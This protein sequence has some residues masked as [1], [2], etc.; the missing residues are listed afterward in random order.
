MTTTIIYDPT[1]FEVFTYSEETS[2]TRKGTIQKIEQGFVTLSGSDFAELIPNSR[3]YFV[4]TNSDYE[5]D[6]IGKYVTLQVIFMDDLDTTHTI[7]CDYSG[8]DYTDDDE[9]SFTL[10]EPTTIVIFLKPSS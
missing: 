3:I 4:S 9:N 8:V 7:R 2:P 1:S 5:Q 10:S 6:G